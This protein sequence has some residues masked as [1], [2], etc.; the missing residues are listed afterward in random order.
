VELKKI[1]AAS[2]GPKA[3]SFRV[4]PG[5]LDLEHWYAN[6]TESGGRVLGEACHFL[7]YLCFLFDAKPVRV[8]AQTA[9]PATGRLPFPDTVTAQ[10][11]FA[12]G[13]SGQ[14]IY[15][16]EGDANF[17]KEALTIYGAGLVAEV[18]NFQE[19]VVHRARKKSSFS[20]SSKGHAE[21]MR[22]WAEFLSGRGEHPL[23]YE[24]SR[25]S[26]L[27]TFAG[28]ESIQQARTVEVRL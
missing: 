10:V 17:P 26:M 19:L 27:L 8:S 24:E 25:A 12:D 9:W 18:I 7:D 20:Y 3:A 14:L 11:E 6:H 21:E 16:A 4:M 13:S 22:A 23:P 1:L 28:I 15:T 2:P 5:A